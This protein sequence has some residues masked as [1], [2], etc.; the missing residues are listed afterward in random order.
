M[1]S[2]GWRRKE[3]LIGGLSAGAGPAPAAGRRDPAV[4][5]S[6]AFLG[7]VGA[8]ALPPARVSRGG[9]EAGWDPVPCFSSPGPQFRLRV[10]NFAAAARVPGS[11]FGVTPITA[12]GFCLACFSPAP[13]SGGT[14]EGGAGTGPM[15]AA[16]GFQPGLVLKRMG[17]VGWLVER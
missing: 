9:S 5:S 7:V 3:A 6:R 16:Q 10:R 1:H 8:G 12:A 15:G 2:G 17:S 14:L 11:V 4:S 13:A